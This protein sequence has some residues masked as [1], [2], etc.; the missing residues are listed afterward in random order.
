[1]L[2]PVCGIQWIL[3]IR[4]DCFLMHLV[5]LARKDYKILRRGAIFYGVW[6]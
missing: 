3:P 2:F 5:D 4:M 6:R 1:M